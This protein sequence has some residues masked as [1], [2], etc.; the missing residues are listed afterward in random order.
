MKITIEHSPKIQVDIIGF[1]I[2][3]SKVLLSSLEKSKKEIEK[4][5]LKYKD[6]QDSGE[7]STRQQDLLMKYDEELENIEAIIYELKLFI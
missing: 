5:Y 4:K 7:A 1:D 3:A 6:I 2:E